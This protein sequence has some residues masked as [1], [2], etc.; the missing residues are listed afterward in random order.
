[1]NTS[2]IIVAMLGAIYVFSIFLC[3]YIVMREAN[4]IE[5]IKLIPWWKGSLKKR[6]AYNDYNYK[7]S[8]LGKIAMKWQFRLTWGGAVFFVIVA[9]IWRLFVR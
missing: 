8:L 3:Q 5:K 2:Q 1:M 7:L 9:S 6:Y 4:K